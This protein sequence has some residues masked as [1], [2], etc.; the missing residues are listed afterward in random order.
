MRKRLCKFNGVVVMR[1]TRGIGDGITGVQ[2][3]SVRLYF[4]R[5]KLEARSLV[6]GRRKR[7]GP[8]GAGRHRASEIGM[9]VS[10]RGSG[11][12]GGRTK[13]ELGSSKSFED[14]HGAATLGTAPKWVQLLGWRG[15]WF[16]LRWLFC[17]E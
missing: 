15:F 2:A 14:H 3:G 10:C 1:K 17:V 9:R 8:V 11:E 12:P 7:T 13:L 5:R 6:D 16:G 4:A